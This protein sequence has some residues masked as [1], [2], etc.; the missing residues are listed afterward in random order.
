MNLE[1]EKILMSILEES[2]IYS[3][4]TKEERHIVLENLKKVY[5]NFFEV[6]Y[7]NKEVENMD[8]WFR[9]RL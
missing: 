1:V 6:K 4:L 5:P 3:A 7:E 9:K 8:E 2:P